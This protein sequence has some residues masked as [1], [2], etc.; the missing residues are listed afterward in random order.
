MRKSFILATLFAV[1]IAAPLRAQEAPAMPEPTKEHEWLAKLAGDWESECEAFVPG[2]DSIKAKATGTARTLGGFWLV[3]ESD[4]E[5]MGTPVK[6]ILTLGYD[7]RSKKFV[8]NWVSSCADSYYTYE[9]TLDE[10][11][12]TLTLETTGP[13][14]LN[15][16]ETANFREVLEVQDADH[17]TFT[18]Y[19]EVDSQ[20]QKIVTVTSTRKK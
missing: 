5:M 9:G 17:K 10:A 19:M 3:E 4:G 18:S 12:K 13:S 6:S 14:P 8:G 20:W 7:P 15:P 16:A 1:A 11:G 2:Q